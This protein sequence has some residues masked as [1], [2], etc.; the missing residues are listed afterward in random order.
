MKYIFKG[1]YSGIFYGELGNRDKNGK[2][3]KINNVRQILSYNCDGLLQ[4]SLE[5]P[6]TTGNI[7]MTIVVPNIEIHD[8]IEI[9]PCSE[10]SI[11]KLNVIPEWRL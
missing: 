5:G 7:K 2:I 8:C 9:I 4:L 3:V 11:L 10:E 1:Q 6:P